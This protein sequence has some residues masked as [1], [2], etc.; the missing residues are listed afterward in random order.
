MLN[1][2]NLMAAALTSASMAALSMPAAAWADATP[3]C[4]NSKT[5]LGVI[6]PKVHRMW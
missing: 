3:E 6:I 1:R 4:N 5:P 2:K